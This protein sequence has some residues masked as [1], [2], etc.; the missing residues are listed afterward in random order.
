[1]CCDNRSNSNRANNMSSH[2]SSV[3]TTG[4]ITLTGDPQ[5]DADI[6]AFVNARQNILKQSEFL[7][8]LP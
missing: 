5:A 4:G 8:C 2:S 3:H 1:M 6:L 7:N